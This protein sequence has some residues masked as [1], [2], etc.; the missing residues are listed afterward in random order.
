M[1]VTL[2]CTSNKSFT[3]QLKEI[4]SCHLTNMNTSLQL[5]FRFTEHERPNVLLKTLF[6]AC[7]YYTTKYTVILSTNKW[8]S[9]YCIYTIQGNLL[10]QKRNL[11]CIINFPVSGTNSLTFPGTLQIPRQSQSS[12]SWLPSSYSN[13]WWVYI[14]PISTYFCALKLSTKEDSCLII[15]LSL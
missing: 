10:S 6:S 3:L 15:I 2:H 1:S 4:F 13:F 14:I 5:C 9:I 7:H 11:D 8:A 12:P